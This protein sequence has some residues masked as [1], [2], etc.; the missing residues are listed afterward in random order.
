MCLFI[1]YACRGIDTSIAEIEVVYFNVEGIRV[2]ELWSFDAIASALNEEVYIIEGQE[3]YVPT[4]NDLEITSTT[5]TFNVE[6]YN[7]IYF[8][9][10]RYTVQYWDIEVGYLDV[11]GM[12]DIPI[13]NVDEPIIITGLTPVFDDYPTTYLGDY[14]ITLNFDYVDDPTRV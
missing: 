11:V 13:T 2:K 9:N 10:L 14:E 1:E 4:I 12:V 6:N 7:S 5:A 8:E 3:G